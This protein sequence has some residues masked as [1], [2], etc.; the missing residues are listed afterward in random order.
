MKTI[1]KNIIRPLAGIA[2]FFAVMTAAGCSMV[3]DPDGPCPPEEGDG[4]L[5][6]K[7]RITA[8]MQGVGHDA[9]RAD[10]NNHDEVG[11]DPVSVEEAVNV[12]D[13]AFFIFAGNEDSAPLLARYPSD[14]LKNSVSIV[15]SPGY[16]NVNVNIPE[17][18]MQEYLGKNEIDP[19]GTTP[20]DFRILILANTTA[21]DANT[22]G[23]FSSITASTFGDVTSQVSEMRYKLD[24][25]FYNTDGNTPASRVKGLI[26]MYGL[27]SF[28]TTE[29]M[30]SGSRPEDRIDFGEISLLRAVSKI[31]IEDRI[32]N[33]SADGYPK[34]T[35]ATFGYLKTSGYVC[36]KD[37]GAY[38]NGHQVHTANIP[39]QDN[40]SATVDFIPIPGRE[41]PEWFVYVPEQKIAEANPV[42]NITVQRSA[43]ATDVETYVV[44][45]SGY[46]GKEFNWDGNELLRN[47]IYTLSVTKVDLG[48]EMEIVVDVKDWDKSSLD[49]SYDANVSL[50][51][52]GAL[53]WISGSFKQ[54]DNPQ[55][56]LTLPW[57]GTPTP[58]ECRFTLATPVGREW[59]AYL[60]PVEGA[61]G[62]AFAFLNDKGETVPTV[63]GVVDPQKQSILKIVTTDNSPAQTNAVMLQIVVTLADGS[64]ME[65]NV[66]GND[67]DFKN[68]IIVQEKVGN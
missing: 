13:I 20:I 5:A 28:R 23:D 11:S 34:I 30:I 62:G 4:N 40:A 54:S 53:S 43:D 42:F 32:E 29:A 50:T 2:L 68:Y 35:G 10:D 21:G 65:A 49:L 36:P 46:G 15:G 55:R 64:T 60:I 58:A 8:M 67:K 59:H 26:P 44:P 66:V 48:V 63:S 24:G 6:L 57:T 38:V 39:Q 37:A 14:D 31:R 22:E 1:F 7:F 47:H 12:K 61:Q 45:M 3:N 17:S 52:K 16:Y 51:E 56:I 25:N 18:V 27:K 41:T 33:R 9:T 19:N